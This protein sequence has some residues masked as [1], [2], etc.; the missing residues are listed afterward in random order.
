MP[1]SGI[2][3]AV[4]EL[5]RTR[6]TDDGIKLDLLVHW[7]IVPETVEDTDGETHIQYSYKEN[8]L[9][10]PYEGLKSAVNDFLANQE[11]TLLLKAKAKREEKE[12]S[13]ELSIGDKSKLEDLSQSLVF[14]RISNIDINRP[15]KKYVQVEKTIDAQ[16]LQRWCY[17]TYS[18]LLAHQ[19]TSLAIGDYVII[20]FVDNDLVKPIVIDKIVGF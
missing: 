11:G 8:K 9:T 5:K 13:V 15:D 19:N 2:E 16:V 6:V 18:V 10:I 4:I 20:E 1:Q 7:D 17:V 12:G 14:G 3:P